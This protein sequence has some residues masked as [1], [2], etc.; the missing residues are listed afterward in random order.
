M[1]LSEIDKADFSKEEVFLSFTD[2]L[3]KGSTID[4]DDL[5]KESEVGKQIKLVNT[6]E[7]FACVQCARQDIGYTGNSLCFVCILADARDKRSH[8][9]HY[10][11]YVK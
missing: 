6:H 11:D 2:I 7:M 9:N 4:I 1:K 3:I 5:V 10:F 8:T